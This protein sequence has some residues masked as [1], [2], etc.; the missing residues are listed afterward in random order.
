MAKRSKESN[1]QITKK[2]ENS[3]ANFFTF[4]QNKKN[5]I[6]RLPGLPQLRK[7]RKNAAEKQQQ[8]KFVDQ[9]LQLSELLLEWPYVQSDQ[10]TQLF[11]VLFPI[12]RADL[13]R[14]FGHGR[15]FLFVNETA[16][17]SFSRYPIEF[18]TIPT[19]SFS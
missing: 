10:K 3:V 6:R 13:A 2:T 16:R 5:E 8:S 17:L 12:T 9:K 19:L 18:L 14:H 4:D 11:G 1:T 7:R 15:I